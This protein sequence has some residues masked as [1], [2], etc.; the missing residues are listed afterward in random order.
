MRY[1]RNVLGI[2]KGHVFGVKAAEAS[3]EKIPAFSKEL[4]S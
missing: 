3:E 1:I 4:E 2:S